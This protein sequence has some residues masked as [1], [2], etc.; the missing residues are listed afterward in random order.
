MSISTNDLFT[1]FCL[2]CLL[3]SLI[4]TLVLSDLVCS[5]M[6]A[7]NRLHFDVVQQISEASTRLRMSTIAFGTAC[8]LYHR[9]FGVFNTKELDPHVSG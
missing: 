2:C 7:I 3:K 5:I 6:A 4:N 1:F 8:T 9:F